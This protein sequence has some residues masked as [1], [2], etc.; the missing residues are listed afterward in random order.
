VLTNLGSGVISG[1]GTIRTGGITNG[2]QI[3]LSAGLTDVYGSL[4]G[5]S[6]SK[7]IVSGGGTSTFYSNV[8]MNS[9]S[10]FR[11]STGSTAVF[12]GNVSGTDF[13]TGSGTT[14]FEDGSSSVGS[15]MMPAGKAVV[16]L[17]ADV[18]ASRFLLDELRI[19][20]RASV[21]ASGADSGV[22]AVNTLAIET[23]GTLDLADNDLI[24]N[25]GVFSE[26]FS[27]VI[28]G[29]GNTSGGITSS[30]SDGSQI[31]ALFD[32]ALVGATDWAGQSIGPSAIVGKY[33]YF[34]DANIDGQVTGDDYT[35]IDANL[36]TAPA[37]GLGWLS[38]DL[39]LD[40]IVSGDDYTVIDANLGL[41]SGNP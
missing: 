14:I 24:V 5:S 28:A 38:G 2:G 25:N 29:F 33:T 30:T 4:T 13:F 19:S 34:G 3:Q 37:V 31:L 11:V 36:N 20:G 16:E 17:P 41:G 27:H 23:G 18:T 8:T 26:I 32:N 9:G 15:M 22:S 39:N 10:E 6:G 1:R 7:V 12:F 40:G 21:A 35:V